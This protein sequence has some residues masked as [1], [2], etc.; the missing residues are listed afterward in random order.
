MKLSKKI[1]ILFLALTLLTSLIM[2]QALF[3]NKSEEAVVKRVIDKDLIPNTNSFIELRSNSLDGKYTA[4]FY[5][6]STKLST[7]EMWSIR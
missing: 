4:T 5:Y 7:M 3:L 6:K 2:V 1:S